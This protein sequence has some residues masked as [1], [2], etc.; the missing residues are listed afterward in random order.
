MHN[1]ARF[2]TDLFS[3]GTHLGN[4]SSALGSQQGILISASTV[5]HCGSPVWKKRP[6]SELQ[7]IGLLEEHCSNYVNVKSADTWHKVE[8][9]IRV[10]L[11]F[12]RAWMSDYICMYICLCMYNTHTTG[13]ACM[14]L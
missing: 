12:G 11:A 6:C 3:V 1:D 7:C 5:S 10:N 13:Y 4:R 2:G 8:Q 14:S 9:I